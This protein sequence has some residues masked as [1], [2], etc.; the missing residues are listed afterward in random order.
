MHRI[1]GEN[2]KKNLNKQNQ[3]KYELDGLIRKVTLKRQL[4]TRNFFF[5][6]MNDVRDILNIFYDQISCNVYVHIYF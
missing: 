6:M 1:E 5:P 4:F 2:W 3:E